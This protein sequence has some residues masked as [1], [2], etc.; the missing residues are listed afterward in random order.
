[1][2]EIQD[3]KGTDTMITHERNAAVKSGYYF[4][5]AAMSIALVER[6]GDR[7]PGAAGRWIEVPAVAALALTPVLGALFLMFLPVLGFLLVGEKGSRSVAAL[8]SG[9]AGE[10]ALAV[11]PG[12]VAGE[13]HLT[14]AVARREAKE[15]EIDPVDLRLAELEREIERRRR[16]LAA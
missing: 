1:M 5:P 8:F 7:L 6:D 12:W 15:I 16:A 2:R 10:L 11:A 14:G 9:G 3:R 13:A 4:N